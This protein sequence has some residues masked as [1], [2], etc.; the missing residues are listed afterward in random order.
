MSVYPVLQLCELI[1]C[2]VVS[3]HPVLCQF[4]PV[5]S[6]VESSC[7][8]VCQFILCWGVQMHPVLCKIIL[9]TLH[10][11]PYSPLRFWYLVSASRFLAPDSPLL[12]SAPFLFSV[13]QHEMT[14][15]FLSDR[16]PLW[17]HSKMLPM[18]ISFPKTV[19]LP[20][21]LFR[22]SLCMPSLPGVC[23]LF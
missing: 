5:L 1:L 2:W 19:D 13:H 16:N 20:C 4:T 21:F 15:P 8:E 3:V 18:N 7:F 17:T 22:A 23:C 11:F 12:V 9:T 10:T 14:F 6:C